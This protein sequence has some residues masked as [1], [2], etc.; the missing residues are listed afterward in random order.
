MPVCGWVGKAGVPLEVKGLLMVGKIAPRPFL[1]LHSVHN[2][3]TPTEESIEMF[4]RAKQP[5]ELYSPSE[6]DH[7]MFHEENMHVL[8]IVSDWLVRFFPV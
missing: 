7:F 2:S 1:L 8:Q 4:Q 6:I 3:V 5:V